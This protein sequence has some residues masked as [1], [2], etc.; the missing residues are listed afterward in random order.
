MTRLSCRNSN[1][2]FRTAFAVGASGD[3]KLTSKSPG[4]PVIMCPFRRKIKKFN[5]HMTVELDPA[6]A[7][8]TNKADCWD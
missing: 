8:S 6:S 7:V 2:Y 4:L 3:P 5:H 1:K